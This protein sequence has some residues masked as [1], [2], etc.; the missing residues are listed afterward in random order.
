M[1]KLARAGVFALA[2]AVSPVVHADRIQVFSVRGADCAPC[3]E[4]AKEALRNADGV[5][6]AEPGARG[7]EVTVWMK[8]GVADDA[9]LDRLAKAGLQAV[10][11]P[12]KRAEKFPG[13][14]DVATLTEDGS[15]VGP[16]ARLRVPGKFTVFDVYADWCAPCK[17]VDS[18]L[19]ALL[20]ERKDVAVRKLNV[21]DFDSPLARELGP[22]FFSLP[23]VIVFA[24]GG[25]RTVIAGLDIETLDAALTR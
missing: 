2:A 1:K 24:P 20:A 19:R 15:R 11:G 6:K 5:K 25:K 9:I 17:T 22:D 12:P 21:V 18:R 8:D 3:A 23:Y 10:V 13:D 4:R 14:A 16:L 7:L